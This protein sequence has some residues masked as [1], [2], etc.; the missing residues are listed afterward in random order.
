[1]F[2]FE[3][4]STKQYWK[5]G[6]SGTCQIKPVIPMCVDFKCKVAIPTKF[7]HYA[8]ETSMGLFGNPFRRDLRLMKQCAVVKGTRWLKS[9]VS[10]IREFVLCAEAIPRAQYPFILP[11]PTSHLPRPIC[12]GRHCNVPH[13]YTQITS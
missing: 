1:M 9:N 6:G 4:G 7:V 11:F 12:K 10:L 13:E 5:T 2:V 3:A 8:S